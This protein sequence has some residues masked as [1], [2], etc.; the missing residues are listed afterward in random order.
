[1]R[2]RPN[3]L[4]GNL[5]TLLETTT[6]ANRSRGVVVYCFDGMIITNIDALMPQKYFLTGALGCSII[7]MRF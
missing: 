1:M 5:L 3:V 4:S 2:A 7:R 6:P